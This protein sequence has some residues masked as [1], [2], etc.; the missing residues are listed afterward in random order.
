MDQT[1][2]VKDA[3]LEKR[4]GNLLVRGEGQKKGKESET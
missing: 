2:Q 1:N 3:R 4:V